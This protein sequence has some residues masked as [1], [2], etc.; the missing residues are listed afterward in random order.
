MPGSHL[1]D[2]PRRTATADDGELDALRAEV[3]S[4]YLGLGTFVEHGILDNKIQGVHN[5]TTYLS[6]PDPSP[7]GSSLLGTA[8]STGAEVAAAA[9]AAA[10]DGATQA[11]V[12]ALTVGSRIVAS[13]FHRGG[14]RHSV[15]DPVQFTNKYYIALSN[16]WPDSVHHLLKHMTT[17]S[18]ARRIRDHVYKMRG[19]PAKIIAHQQNEILDA[20][21]SAI[22]AQT[23]SGNS[24]VLG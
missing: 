7:V 24:Q 4:A 22:R 12:A 8:L 23:Q 16:T 9:L 13:T 21:V 19:Q 5:M 3:K 1:H 14:N 6:G 18:E 17:I 2:A 11:L 10:T 15:L 20:W